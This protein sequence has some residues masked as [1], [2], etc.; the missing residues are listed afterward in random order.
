MKILQYK[1]K[2]I[3]QLNYGNSHK[4]EYYVDIEND[5]AKYLIT[6]KIFMVL[7]KEKTHWKNSKKQYYHIYWQWF[8]LN[9]SLAIDW[10]THFLFTTPP[11]QHRLKVRGGS[12]KM[13]YRDFPD[14]PM[15]KTL[16]FQFMGGRFNLWFGEQRSHVPWVQKA[17]T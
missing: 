10:L 5:V 1:Q 3:V 12:I 4:V 15:F 11:L 2:K 13:R 9:K 14:G 16:A 17:K 8:Y 6:W 7:L